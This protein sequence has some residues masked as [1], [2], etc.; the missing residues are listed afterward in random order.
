[1]VME[2][3]FSNFRAKYRTIRLKLSYKV[4]ELS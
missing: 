2:R 1:M 3:V 4:R